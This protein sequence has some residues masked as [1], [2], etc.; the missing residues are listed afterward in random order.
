M[1]VCITSRKFDI[2]NC[3]GHFGFTPN[4]DFGNFRGQF[5]YPIV[6]TLEIFMAIFRCIGLIPNSEVM[7]VSSN[8]I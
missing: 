2:V 8:I 3:H 5:Y 1:V 6:L 7:L 4:F